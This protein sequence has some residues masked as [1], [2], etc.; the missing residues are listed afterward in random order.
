[1][2]HAVLHIIPKNPQ[3]EHVA[4]NVEPSSMH[5][6]CRCETYYLLRA[7]TIRQQ[8]SRNDPERINKG[9]NLPAQGNLIEKN[10]EVNYYQTNVYDGET[11]GRDIIF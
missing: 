9:I 4:K 5:E 8:V 2:A 11:S 1:M 10:A 7:Q 6:H 3:V